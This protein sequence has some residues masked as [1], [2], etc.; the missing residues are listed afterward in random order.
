MT[1]Q[2]F[3]FRAVSVAMATAVA[4][5]CSTQVTGSASTPSTASK[6]PATTKPAPPSAR[7]GT[8]YAA[9]SG[10]ACEVA[11]TGPVTI[12]LADARLSSL[13]VLKIN[14]DSVEV[15]MVLSHGPS[16]GTTVKNGCTATFFAGGPAAAYITWCSA[17]PPDM[18]GTEVKRLVTVKSIA[19]GTAI[20]SLKSG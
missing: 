9:C 7:D 5:G 4:A 17:E 14:A 1:R 6:S 13:K 2:A 18:P 11:V 20:L 16:I 19:D 3:R 12:P 10:G 8:N 15:G